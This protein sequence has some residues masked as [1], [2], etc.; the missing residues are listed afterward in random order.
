VILQK[1]SSRYCALTLRPQAVDHLRLAVGEARELVLP[2][3]L[4]RRGADDQ[5]A[6]HAEVARVQLGRGNG[7]DRLAETHLVADQCASGTHRDQRTLELV[8]IE[9]DLEQFREGPV[10]GAAGVGVGQRGAAAFAIAQLRYEPPDFVV[11][12]QLVPALLRGAQQRLQ[13]FEPLPRQRPAGIGVEQQTGLLQKRRRARR[14][15]AESHLMRT[16]VVQPYLAVRGL[17]S[18]CE[19]LLAA[20]PLLEPPERELDVLAGAE[21]IRRE[22]RAGAEVL[23]RRAAADGHPIARAAL[24]I[25]DAKIGE[26]RIASEILEAELL[27]APELAAQRGLPVRGLQIQ[28]APCS[29]QARFGAWNALAGLGLRG[30]CAC[31]AGRHA[32]TLSHFRGSFPF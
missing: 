25:V 29:R 14:P 8:G 17:E 28:R 7:L 13:S 22:V 18:A 12:A 11:A 31:G 30:R 6:L 4:E 26:D 20:A 32:A 15:G 3:V 9:L 2:L 10:P 23:P 16:R 1:T 19:R 5:H 24:G 27:L 21:V